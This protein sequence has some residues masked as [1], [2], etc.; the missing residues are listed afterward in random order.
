MASKQLILGDSWTQIGDAGDKLLISV[1][2]GIVRISYQSDIPT[3]DDDSFIIGVGQVHTAMVWTSDDKC[4]VK[5][6]LQNTPTEIVYD[7]LAD[8]SSNNDKGG[9]GLMS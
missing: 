6:Y 1:K 3:S 7:K 9:S 5:S 8:G 2:K 4:Y